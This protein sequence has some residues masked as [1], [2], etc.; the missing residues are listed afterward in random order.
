METNKFKE[1]NR[2][3]K[4][5]LPVEIVSSARIDIIIIPAL[6]SIGSN[7]GS[8]FLT[9]MGLLTILI[10]FA[11]TVGSLKYYLTKVKVND[12]N[13]YYKRD[14]ISKT[15]FTIPIKNVCALRTKQTFLYRLFDMANISID[16]IADKKEEIHL[17]MT[18]EDLRLFLEAINEYTEEPI[19][20]RGFKKQDAHSISESNN[21]S[22]SL[23]QLI[24]GA[25]TQNHLKG[26]ALAFAGLFAVYNKISD[27][28]NNYIEQ[29]ADSMEK[30]YIKASISDIIIVLAFSYLI[31]LIAWLTKVI[32]LQY[33]LEIKFRQKI[34]NKEGGLITKRSSSLRRDKIIALETKI[35]PIESLLN[36]QTIR[37]I[38]ASNVLGEDNKE[39][40]TF[41][42][43]KDKRFIKSWWMKNDSIED[44][45]L[46]KSG[47]GLFWFCL[48]STVYIYI[49]IFLL[50]TYFITKD[51]MWLEL[52][53]TILTVSILLAGMK[54]MRSAIAISQEFILIYGGSIAET[55]TFLPIDKVEA[56][57]IK[58]SFI[59]QK[60]GRASI[61]IMTK[62]ETFNVRSLEVEDVRKIHSYL[63]Y[64]TELKDLA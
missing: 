54:K 19:E 11:V 64:K 53:G 38:Q 26:A 49:S 10:V 2:M 16:T 56:V 55:K 47:K 59:Q 62:G 17:T 6:L 14:I 20:I 57:A 3:G 60:T 15:L 8:L 43:W 4:D 41:Y 45:P 13:I 39:K 28:L 5:V 61:Y 36:I 24:L 35:N 58:Q 9:I 46:I 50:I 48:L 40:F 44:A 37:F 12:G 18:K 7:K 25:A 29:I 52:T 63:L 51:P 30:L 34:I 1:F 33:G 23:L 21:F 31:F 22:Y 27:Y 42:A 32:L